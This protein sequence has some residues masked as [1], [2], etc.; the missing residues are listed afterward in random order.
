MSSAQESHGLVR[1][2]R[3][4]NNPTFWPGGIIPFVFIEP[5]RKSFN[6]DMQVC[7]FY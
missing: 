6:G 7:T 5:F 1:V 3:Q 4:A 2:K